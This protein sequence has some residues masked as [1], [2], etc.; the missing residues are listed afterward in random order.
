MF[1]EI[2]GLIALVTEAFHQ[3]KIYNTN[4]DSADITFFLLS[5]SFVLRQNSEPF[6]GAEIP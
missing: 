4:S 5:L 6:W 2:A 1:L 3:Y